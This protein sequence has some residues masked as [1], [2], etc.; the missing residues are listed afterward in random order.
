MKKDFTLSE[1]NVVLEDITK[2]QNIPIHDEMEKCISDMDK[3]QIDVNEDPDDYCPKPDVRPLRK[4]KTRIQDVECEA[5]LDSGA[6]SSTITKKALK[7]LYNGDRNMNLKISRPH[8]TVRFANG[9]T[10]LCSTVTLKVDNEGL[11]KEIVFT[12]LNM[13]E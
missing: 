8:H 4:I 7:D 9:M 2:E 13:T 11:C 3:L 5:L 6:Q 12:I 10:E 1:L